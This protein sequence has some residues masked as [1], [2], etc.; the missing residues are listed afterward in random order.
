MQTTVLRPRRSRRARKRQEGAVMLVVMLILMIATASAA[1][2]VQS[3]ASEI[4]AS[5]QER[6]AVQSRYASEAAMMSTISWIDLLG[7]SGQWVGVLQFWAGQTAPPAMLPNYAEPAIPPN[8]RHMAS[9]S[10]MQQQLALPRANGEIPPLSEAEATG[11]GGGGGASGS[12]AGGSTGSGGSTAPAAF[13]DPVGSF[14]PRQAYGPQPEGYV[15]DINDCAQAPSGLSPGAPV[16]G[17]TGSLKVAQ[18][19]CVLTAHVRIG[20]PAGGGSEHWEFGNAALSY[21]KDRFENEHD[22]RATILTPQMLV[23]GQ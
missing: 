19:Y 22:S 5:G 9:R 6:V 15:V 23:P 7:N 18:F 4:N 12:G 1:I 8:N 17:G 21:D 14:G 20:L 11:T 16:G 3:T 10:T 2:S 13:S